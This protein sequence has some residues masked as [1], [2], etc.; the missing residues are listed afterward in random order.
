MSLQNQLETRELS[1][2][3]GKRKGGRKR[4]RHEQ[5]NNNDNKTPIKEKKKRQPALITRQDPGRVKLLL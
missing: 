2:T 5:N 3:T 1:L 4:G